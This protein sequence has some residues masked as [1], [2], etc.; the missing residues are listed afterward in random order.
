MNIY[1]PDISPARAVKRVTRRTQ[2]HTRPLELFDEATLLGLKPSPMLGRI[3]PRH[4]FTASDLFCGAGGTTSGFEA[5][6]IEGKHIVDTLQVVNHDW[7]A[8][9]SHA[10]NHAA[11]KHFIE[12]ITK[13]DANLLVKTSLLWASLECTSFSNA[14]GGQGR[15]ADSRSLA[16]HMDRYIRA[17]NPLYFCVENVR[18]FMS[19]GPLEHKKDKYGR[20][21][22][23]S[24][25]VLAQRHSKTGEPLFSAKSGKPLTQQ[26]VDSGGNLVFEQVPALGAR[27]AHQGP[28]FY[29]LEAE[30]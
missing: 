15:D 30:H 11:A 2:T 13:L 3:G 5:A 1:A 9:A 10:A 16:E 4:W 20:P 25:K 21:M 6:M 19:W 18:E 12:D 17:V 7:L 23:R 22:F 26:V 8:I 14:K 29:P 28:G 27:V 24:V